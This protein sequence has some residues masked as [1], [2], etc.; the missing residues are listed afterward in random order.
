MPRGSNGSPPERGVGVYAD[1]SG[2]GH[3]S[4]PDPRLSLIPGPSMFCP[5]SL[6]PHCGRSGPHTGGGGS[7]SHS[8]GPA[9]TRGVLD[10]PW[11]SGL[12]IPWS[13]AL[14]WGSGLTV[15]ALEYI[16]FSGHVTAPDPPMWRGQALLWTQSSGLRLVRVMA[17]SHTQHFYH[18]T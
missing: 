4:A 14:P 12:Y 8:K 13:D 10:Q 3:V 7:R 16:T 6:G 5:R 15:D 17:W 11:R 2:P 18:A 9:C 1:R